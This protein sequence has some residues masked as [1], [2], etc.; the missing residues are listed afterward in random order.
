MSEA[1]RAVDDA[2]K[3][4]ERFVKSIDWM[5]YGLAE[6]LFD[7]LVAAED[8]TLFDKIKSLHAV[9]PC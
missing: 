1:L 3:L 5:R 8:S 6:S 4:P 9:F 7:I 2:S